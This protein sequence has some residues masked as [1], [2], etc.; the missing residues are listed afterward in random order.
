M[1]RNASILTVAA[2]YRG[3]LMR[4]AGTAITYP[5]GGEAA[6]FAALTAVAEGEELSAEQ[7][8]ALGTDIGT[9]KHLLSAYGL[10]EGA[11]GVGGVAAGEGEPAQHYHGVLAVLQALHELFGGA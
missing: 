11:G 6:F 9:A 5:V 4:H 1:P 3:D 2:P 8:A 7:S 10:H